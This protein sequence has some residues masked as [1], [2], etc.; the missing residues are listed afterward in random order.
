VQYRDGTGRAWRR[1]SDP[2]FIAY[3]ESNEQ[4][5]WRIVLSKAAKPKSV[6]P[7]SLAGCHPPAASS[8]TGA[9]LWQAKP[10]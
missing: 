3:L 7:V 2:T 6:R 10:V 1:G 4:G 5:R 9:R 8:A